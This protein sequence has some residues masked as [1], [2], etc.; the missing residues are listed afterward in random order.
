MVVDNLKEIWNSQAES[1]INFSESDIYKM[2]HKKSASIVKW[3]FYISIVEFIVMIV[4]PFFLKDNTIDMERMHMLNFYNIANVLSYVIAVVFIYLF[5]K[6][7]TQISVQD[8]SKKLMSDILKTRRIVKYYVG[9]QLFL[10]GIVSLI[11]IIKSK[12]E[13]LLNINQTMLW[14]IAVVGV[15][16]VLFVMWLF[17]M[18]IY[19]VLLNKLNTNYKELVKFE[20]EI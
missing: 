2:I 3:I 9:F 10:G 18:L 8:T 11:L 16:I 1:K 14:V 17:Y 20:K 12:D 7:F 19:G 4:L 15:I 6:N 5:Y 13:S